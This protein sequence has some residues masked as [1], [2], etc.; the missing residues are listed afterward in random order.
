M[1]KNESEV[2]RWIDKVLLFN[3]NG[4]NPFSPGTTVHEVLHTFGLEHPWENKKYRNK[5]N[6]RFK[7]AKTTDNIMDY[8]EGNEST[9]E[10]RYRASSLWKWQYEM[11]RDIGKE[12][13]KTR[14][15]EYKYEKKYYE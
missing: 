11:A 9:V 1:E 4:N 2:T 12:K 6:W 5:Y 15:S 13:Y 8:V 10:K 7:Y 14:I 3:I